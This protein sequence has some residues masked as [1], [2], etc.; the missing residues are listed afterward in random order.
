[1]NVPTSFLLNNALT[2]Y[3]ICI[4]FHWD[5][6]F[7]E[8]FLYTL[9]IHVCLCFT[10]KSLSNTWQYNIVYNR[11]DYK[12]QPLI[13]NCTQLLVP[14]I[15]KALSNVQ[16]T[17]WGTIQLGTTLAGFSKMTSLI[18]GAYQMHN[19]I[20]RKCI[21]HVTFSSCCIIPW[22]CHHLECRMK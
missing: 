4:C 22:I 9:A 12:S 14:C 5:W 17:I 13:C 19:N 8:I 2:I 6:K 20:C 1:M 11:D 15:R 18:L 7:I 10:A 21:L 16:I 3:H